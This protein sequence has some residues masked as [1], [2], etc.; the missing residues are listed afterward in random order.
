MTNRNSYAF[1]S[2]FKMKIT[3]HPNWKCPEHIIWR[4]IDWLVGCVQRPIDSEVI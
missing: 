3:N 2:N 4:R 1:F